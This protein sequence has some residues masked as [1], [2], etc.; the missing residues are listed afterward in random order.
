[1]KKKKCRIKQIGEENKNRKLI[2]G[3]EKKRE[4]KQE[5][6]KE[7]GKIGEKKEVKK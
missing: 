3:E 4:N 7:G 1:M 5:N 2:W 6:K